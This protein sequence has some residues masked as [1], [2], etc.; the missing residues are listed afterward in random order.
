MP[1]FITSPSWVASEVGVMVY[2]ISVYLCLKRSAILS[3][4][5]LSMNE[6]PDHYFAKPIRHD[7]AFGLYYPMIYLYLDF[8][9]WQSSTV[10]RLKIYWYNRTKLS[11]LY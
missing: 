9:D 4:S 1:D 5:I 6:K 3:G 10:I 8:P 2:F 7:E 11:V